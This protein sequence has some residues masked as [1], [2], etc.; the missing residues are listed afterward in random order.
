[1]TNLE[2]IRGFLEGSKDAKTALRNIYEKSTKGRTLQIME[3]YKYTTL[4]N[5]ETPIAFLKKDKNV[6]T[7]NT[8]KYSR[9]TTAIQNTIKDLAEKQGYKIIEVKPSKQ[10]DF[11]ETLV[12]IM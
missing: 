3:C 8:T 11:A 4:V 6:L 5:Y 12:C 10:L 9:T 7:L 2:V 1:M